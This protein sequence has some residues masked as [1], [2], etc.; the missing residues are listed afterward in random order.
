[1]KQ[2]AKSLKERA[3]IAAFVGVAVLAMAL[4]AC[5]TAQTDKLVA[6]LTN[7]NRG[8]AAVDQTV[9]QINATVYN[10]CNALVTTAT[11]INDIAGN[12]SKASPYTSIANAVI[13]NYCQA[14]GVQA[15][16]IAQSISVTAT[17]VSA[18]KS[19][20]AA[21]KKACAS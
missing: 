15:A 21:N 11:A 18:A 10:Q 14:P 13:N 20:L 17:S 1:M 9:Q 19:T 12:C 3:V 2:F 8:L 16:G 6:G 7:F 5:S 4:G